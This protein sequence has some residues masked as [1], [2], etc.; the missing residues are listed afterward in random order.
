[1]ENGNREQWKSQAGFL[2]AAIGSA[3]G[4]GNL[5]RFP[6]M[7]YEYGGGAF[8][9]PYLVALVTAGFP[10]LILEYGV[11]Q[12]MQGS[13]PIAMARINP[14]WEWLGWWCV[15]FVM[16]GIV[17]YYNVII[18]W[19]LHY[20][21]NSFSL[22][23]AGDPQSYFLNTYL[24]SSDDPGKIGLIRTPI[25]YEVLAVWVINWYIGYRGVRKGIE[26]ASKIFIPVLFVLTL[27]LT[28]WSLS[29]DGAMEGLRALK[30]SFSR[31]MDVRVWLAAYGQIFF[32]L[33]IGFGI[34][35]AYASYLPRHS[36]I[37]SSALITAVVNSSYSLLAAV[38]VF[39]TLGYM[40]VSSG[41]P[42]DEVVKQGAALAFIAYPQAIDLLP[43]F[44]SFFSALFFLILV[45]AGLSSSI[46]IIE[47]FN[48]A[49][50]DKFGLDRRK[51]ISAMCGIGFLGSIIFTTNGGA[52]WI[53]I[54]D[55]FITQYGLVT[56]GVLESILVGW[57]L[58]AEEVRQFI[59]EHSRLKLGRWWNVLVK[60]FIPV[61]LGIIIIQSFCADFDKSY[62]GFAWPWLLLIGVDWLLGCLIAAFFF[63][64]RR[65]L[66]HGSRPGTH[67]GAENAGH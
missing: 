7:A 33:S 66:K 30:P 57:V 56:V 32:T 5:W 46:S 43:S 31:V 49:L 53:D 26:K 58:G 2:M 65:G 38:G 67:G 20:F 51:G 37:H 6:Y 29:L 15:L 25:L 45:L 47:A 40:A 36:N 44:Q 35:I 61:V 42:L 48:A 23:W 54:V 9:V 62:G 18:A 34:M 4:L 11:G 50:M 55:H 28:L 12:K 16:F 14:R 52:S 27:L 8:L 19:C 17:L 39:A 59:N 60:Y 24:N 10:L 1:M 41:K 63:A 21:L 22:P 64:T 13:A 3:V